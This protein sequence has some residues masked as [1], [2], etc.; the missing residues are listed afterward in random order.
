[1]KKLIYNENTKEIDVMEQKNCS[2]KEKPKGFKAW[3]KNNKIFFEIF[4][5]FFVGVMSIILSVVGLRI[6]KKTAEIYQK[7]LKIE[8]DNREPLFQLKTELINENI[9]KNQKEYRH[10]IKNEGGSISYATAMIRKYIEV[11]IISIEGKEII[12]PI[13]FRAPISDRHYTE[14]RFGVQYNEF[15]KNFVLHEIDCK[16]D[17][18]TFSDELSGRIALLIDD[19][20]FYSSGI[21]TYIEIV[22]NDYQNK[23][24]KEKYEINNV[25]FTKGDKQYYTKSMSP[26]YD[27]D[28][29]IYLD[30]VNENNM[31]SIA[32]QAKKEFDR[33]WNLEENQNIEK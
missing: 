31:E 13:I 2:E 1:M 9:E 10:I 8:E 18:L 23:Q 19:T 29:I 17:M 16:E 28:N 14:T 33:R 32:K 21:H 6:N 12:E 22:Y 26:E 3:L 27:E 5:L 4:S 20:R 25:Y 11:G 15:D 30:E 24:V 7:Q